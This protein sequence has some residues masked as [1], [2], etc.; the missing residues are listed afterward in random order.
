MQMHI[1]IN[2]N[3]EAP[4]TESVRIAEQLRF[5]FHGGAWHGPALL[6]IL[7][8]VDAGTAA[9]HPIKG[10]HSIWEIVNHLHA[11]T[12]AIRKRV[13][14][15]VVELEGESDWPPVTDTTAEA[16]QRTLQEWTKEHNALEQEVARLAN[17][18][19]AAKIPNRTH[20]LWFTLHGAVQ[21]DLY[22]A[23]QI[24]MLKK[25]AVGA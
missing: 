25:A 20:S 10:A 21:H 8:D 1:D 9:A 22:H 12:G 5:A 18:R 3:A 6:E 23:G 15:E 16:W 4:Q 13:R 14:L 7:S 2:Q 24:A 11:W 17:E 19:L